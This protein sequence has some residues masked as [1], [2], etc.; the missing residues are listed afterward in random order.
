MVAAVDTI[1]AI[2]AA[3]TD[4]IASDRDC[5]GLLFDVARLK[6]LCGER[7]GGEGRRSFARHVTT[8]CVS[9]HVHALHNNVKCA[10]RSAERSLGGQQNARRAR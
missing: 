10:I 9:L 3:A 2:C 7:A 4:D 1:D 6:I 5:F 8:D